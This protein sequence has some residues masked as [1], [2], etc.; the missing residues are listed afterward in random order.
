[1][2]VRRFWIVAVGML[3]GC[4][5]NNDRGPGD[6]APLGI[7]AVGANGSTQGPQPLETIGDGSDRRDCRMAPTGVC[8]CGDYIAGLPDGVFPFSAY[9]EGTGCSDGIQFARPECAYVAELSGAVARATPERH[10]GDGDVTFDVCPDSDGMR[11][12]PFDGAAIELRSDASFDPDPVVTEPIVGRIHVE[13][14]D[15][16]F[17]DGDYQVPES[18]VPQRARPVAGDRVSAAGD[19]VVD[20]DHEGWTEIHEARALAVV[21]SVS[22]SVSYLFVNAFFGAETRQESHLH[23]DV[24]VPRPSD[25]TLDVF[26]CERA[27][28]VADGC[29]LSATGSLQIATRTEANGAYGVCTVE[30]DR[31][32]AMVPEPFGCHPADG[33]RGKTFA[34]VGCA[35][36]A[37]AGALRATWSAG[38][39]P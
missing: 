26:T 4:N 15:C 39:T 14:Q 13:I 24:R 28:D 20:T 32:A 16:R 10:H 12:D 2:A 18:A 27:Y 31:P 29:P 34:D 22:P 3:L 25:R 6:V 33:C 11:V 36:V 8:S 17:F 1:M 23:L 5:G 21:R 35:H 9:A 7:C 37:F 30:L 19:W 38:T